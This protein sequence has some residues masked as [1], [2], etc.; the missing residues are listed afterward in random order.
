MD[1][2]TKGG[3]SFDLCKRNDFLEK[4]GLNQPGFRKTGTT[5]V[6][7]VFQVQPAF[8]RGTFFVFLGLELCLLLVRVNPFLELKRIKNSVL[9]FDRHGPGTVSS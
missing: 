3:F 5:I 1:L 8:N 7:L 4:K 9:E 6:G 2:S